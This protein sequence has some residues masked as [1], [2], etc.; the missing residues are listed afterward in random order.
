MVTAE[1]ERA[2][3]D[4]V[5]KEK[6]DFTL[7]SVSSF[8]RTSLEFFST[9]SIR[10]ALLLSGGANVLQC[11]GPDALFGPS[12]YPPAV[13]AGHLVPR[14]KALDKALPLAIR[15]VHQFITGAATQSCPPP[16]R[17]CFF[18]DVRDFALSHVL[19]AEKEEAAGERFVIVADKFCNKQ[20]AEVISE[21]FPDLSYRLPTGEQLKSGDFPA[22]GTPDF[23]NRRSVEV[24]GM[25]YRSFTESIVD[26]AKALQARRVKNR[27]DGMDGEISTRV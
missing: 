18:V 2:A 21:N 10:N 1:Q 26:T 20:M 12:A 14:D 27:V 3:W 9:A 11:I 22:G 8:P 19:A 24:L 23:D 25:K 13:H 15:L 16:L 7:T 5:E 6:P 17:S 4:F